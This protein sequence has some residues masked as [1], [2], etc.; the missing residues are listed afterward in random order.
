MPRS[1]FISSVTSDLE[2]HFSKYSTQHNLASSVATETYNLV[3]VLLQLLKNSTKVKDQS[4]SEPKQKG[5]ILNTDY[6]SAIAY[7]EKRVE[8]VRQEVGVASVVCER[9][10]RLWNLSIQFNQLEPD[11]DKV[12]LKDYVINL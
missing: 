10:V 8:N 12:S 3:D 11:V 7:I 6:L 1:Q 9:R 4:S 2:I 5:N